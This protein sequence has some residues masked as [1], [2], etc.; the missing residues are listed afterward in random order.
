MQKELAMELLWKFLGLPYIW[1]GDDP[2]KGFDCSGLVIEVL[3]SV[4]I[5]P[6]VGDWTANDLF[7]NKFC[8]KEIEVPK[9][10]VLVFWFNGQKAVHVEMCIDDK[11]CI[12][13]SGGGPRIL[14][15]QDAINKNAYVKM[16]PISYRDGIKRFVD[17]FI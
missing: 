13:A 1:G 12:G 17:P 9:A 15:E 4:G 5:L 8:G 16:R 11:Y 6:H 14:S 2:V 7:W 10:G 3:K